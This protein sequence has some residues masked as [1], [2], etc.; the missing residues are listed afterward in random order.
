MPDLL[1]AHVRE[2]DAFMFRMESDPLLRS[3]ITAVIVFDREPEWDVLVDRVERATRLVPAFRAKL[4]SSPFGLAPPGWV[5]D[6]DFELAWHL[7]RVD[8]PAPHTLDMVMEMARVAGMTAFDP[9]RPLWEFTLVSGLADGQ[10]AL[11]MKVHH[12]LTDGVGGIDLA[13][14]VVDADRLPTD[15]G[16]MPG[17]PSGPTHGAAA[18]LGDS[19]GFELSRWARTA[20]SLVTAAPGATVQLVRHPVRTAASVAETASSIARF[21]RPVSTTMSPVMTERRLLW[22]FGTLDVPFA[23]LRAAGRSGDGTLNDA[24]L[25]GITGGLRRYHERHVSLV[26]SLR[27]AMPINT[28]K[29]EDP[30]GGNRI[31][32]VRFEVPVAEVDPRARMRALSRTCSAMRHESALP[33]SEAVAGVLNLLPI[34]VTGGML[35]HVDFLASNVPGF[36]VPVYIGGARVESFYAFGPTLGASANVTLMS[37]RGTCH[38]GV[39]TDHGAVPDPD[40]FL[41]C[42]AEGFDE[43]M[44]TADP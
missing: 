8:A 44:A 1:Q 14:H 13:A 25:A 31:T 3:T 36:P 20:R 18:R 41:R 35:K 15:L 17:V 26:P 9:A 11:L 27:V 39:T 43:V 24:F 33:Y 21:V 22:S 28:R 34:S 19:L 30:A 37:Y 10:A 42:L 38:V 5:L 29:P 32:L 23:G 2:T 6:A 40:V 4:V 12:A 16:P 7:R